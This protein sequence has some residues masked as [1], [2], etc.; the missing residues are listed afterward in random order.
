MPFILCYQSA[1]ECHYLRLTGG[2]TAPMHFQPERILLKTC[3]QAVKNS[4]PRVL[5]MT[6]FDSKLL[7]PDKSIQPRFTQCQQGYRKNIK[8][9]LQIFETKMPNCS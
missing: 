8:S 2:Q 5:N 6:S 7:L 3:K 4:A 1:V 9:F